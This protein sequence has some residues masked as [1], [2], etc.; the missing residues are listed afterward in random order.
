MLMPTLEVNEPKW[1]CM[2]SAECELT[3]AGQVHL[4]STGYLFSFRET[5]GF[6]GIPDFF[7]L[8]RNAGADRKWRGKSV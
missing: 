8:R 3:S 5:E 4:I 6:I 1:P 7:D 2:P